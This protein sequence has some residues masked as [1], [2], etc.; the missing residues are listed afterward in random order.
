MKYAYLVFLSTYGLITYSKADLTQPEGTCKSSED[1]GTKEI[2]HIRNGYASG[3]C[4]QDFLLPYATIRSGSCESNDMTP[5]SIKEECFNVTEL[6][7]KL[8][9]NAGVE[10]IDSVAFNNGRIEP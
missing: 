7:S 9:F 5:I 6:F 3:I 1:C 10:P 8:G 2:C 4:K